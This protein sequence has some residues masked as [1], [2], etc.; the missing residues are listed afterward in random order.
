LNVGID[1]K[2]SEQTAQSNPKRNPLN[3]DCKVFNLRWK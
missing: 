1:W 3:C 2:L